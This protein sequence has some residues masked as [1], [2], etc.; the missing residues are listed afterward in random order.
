MSLKKT[1]LKY[2]REGVLWSRRLLKGGLKSLLIRDHP[3]MTSAFF[4]GE[5]SKIGQI[6]QQIVVKKTA[7][8]SGVGVKNRENLL[9]F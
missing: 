7:D 4:R 9:T 6:C 1:T 8:G 5:G 2:K 3:F